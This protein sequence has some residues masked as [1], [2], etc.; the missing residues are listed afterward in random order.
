MGKLYRLSWAELPNLE[1]KL[2]SLEVP[3][4][5]EEDP[6]NIETFALVKATPYILEKNE[7]RLSRRLESSEFRHYLIFNRHKAFTYSLLNTLLVRLVKEYSNNLVD[8]LKTAQDRLTRFLATYAPLNLSDTEG[9]YH[10][11]GEF[12]NSLLSSIFS[13]KGFTADTKSVHHTINYGG[14]I[15]D[16]PHG[17]GEKYLEEMTDAILTTKRAYNGL[18]P[19]LIFLSELCGGCL[20]VNEYAETK[21]EGIKTQVTMA[22]TLI[23]EIH[24]QEGIFETQE[25][26]IK[27]VALHNALGYLIKDVPIEEIN[28]YKKVADTILHHKVLRYTLLDCFLS[29]SL[30][31]Y[32]VRYDKELTKRVGLEGVIDLLPEGQKLLEYKQ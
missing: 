16:I 30:S 26:I 12:I 17:P 27:L 23:R 22:N 25:G 11:D 20:D 7:D 21:K 15:L 6:I 9:T 14:K 24:S 1:K 3:E 18:L 19:S 2:R 31:E 8:N 28:K 5:K 10:I 4:Y 13:P 29:L 32:F